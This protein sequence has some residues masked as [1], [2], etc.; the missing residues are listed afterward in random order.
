MK[1]ENLIAIWIISYCYIALEIGR[2]G[3]D[4]ENNENVE[5]RSRNQIDKTLS[6]EMS[7]KILNGI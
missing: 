1:L 5:I 2:L 3:V 4:Q 7:A 6:L